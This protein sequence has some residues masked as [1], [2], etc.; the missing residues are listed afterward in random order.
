MSYKWAPVYKH[1]RA[2][3]QVLRTLL[4]EVMRDIKTNRQIYNDFERVFARI[5]FFT[6]KYCGV[7]QLACYDITNSICEHLD[8]PIPYVCLCGYGPRK[9][10]QKLRMTYRTKTL[11]I[12][13]IRFV[14]LMDVCKVLDRKGIDYRKAGITPTMKNADPME[15][16]LCRNRH[17]F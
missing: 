15:S 17:R 5:S 12:Y 8:I 13:E 14:D 6:E 3:H 11:G 1:S 10:I 4:K 9:A 16:F 2:S 7:G